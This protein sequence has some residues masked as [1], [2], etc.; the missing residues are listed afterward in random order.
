VIELAQSALDD[1][2]DIKEYYQEQDAE[3]VAVRLVDSILKSIKRL[4]DHPMSGR[5]VPELESR[6]IRE[7]IRPPFRIVYW[8]RGDLISIVRVWRSERLLVMPEDR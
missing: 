7:I 2:K 6:H 5:P 3:T 1:L 8:V 4:Q